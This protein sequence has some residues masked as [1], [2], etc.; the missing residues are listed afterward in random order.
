MTYEYT[1]LDAADTSERLGDQ[2]TTF[3]AAGWELVCVVSRPGMAERAHFR[4]PVLPVT[5]SGKAP[6]R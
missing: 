6:K 1:H 4:R 3:G 5:G 2:F